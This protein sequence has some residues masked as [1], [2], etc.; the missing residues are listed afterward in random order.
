MFGY[1]VCSCCSLYHLV[2]DFIDDKVC[3]DC[4]NKKKKRKGIAL[5]KPQYEKL[6]KERLEAVRKF[7]RPT[8]PS[9][10]SDLFEEM[11]NKET[12]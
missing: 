12:D 6:C 10:P 3:I 4:S 8:L 1:K 9:Y 7:L 5:S 2:E 11:V